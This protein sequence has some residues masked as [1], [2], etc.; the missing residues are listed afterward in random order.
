M[1]YMHFKIQNT[2]LNILK[3]VAKTLR[4][5]MTSTISTHLVK[6]VKVENFHRQLN[7]ISEDIRIYLPFKVPCSLGE[8]HFFL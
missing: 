1:I 3:A 7:S 2:T 6:K 4:F 8:N 5:N